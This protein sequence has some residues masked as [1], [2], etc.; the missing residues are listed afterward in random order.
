M[1]A[2][3]KTTLE[4]NVMPVLKDCRKLIASEMDE[5]TPELRE[6][7]DFALCLLALMEIA[8]GDDRV[9]RE[10]RKSVNH[11]MLLRPTEEAGRGYV[12][13]LAHGE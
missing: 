12:D 7:W 2:A 5:L 6:V 13:R 8:K 4:N 3:F 10:L 9:G 11:S 1:D